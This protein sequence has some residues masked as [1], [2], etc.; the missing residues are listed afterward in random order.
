MKLHSN[1]EKEGKKMNRKIIPILLLSV[2]I[3]MMSFQSA[4]AGQITSATPDQNTYSAGQTGSV[5]VTIYNDRSYTIR[6]DQLSVT[7]NYYYTDST[8]YIQTFYYPSDTLPDEI[9]AGQSKTYEVAIS[10]PNNIA[11]GYPTTRVQANTEIWHSDSGQWG[12]DYTPYYSNLKFY[13]ES[14]YKQLYSDSQ[15]QLDQEKS[16]NGT[17]STNVTMLAITT[18]LFAGALAFLMFLLHTRRP[19]PTAQ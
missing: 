10:L 17:L 11:P 15:Q 18:T 9:Q 14:A 13:I 1:I 4:K 5:S 12:S 8:V 2:L 3:T 19:R 6:V 16:V 7:L